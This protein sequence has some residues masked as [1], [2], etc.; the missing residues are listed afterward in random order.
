[1]LLDKLI[2]YAF[3]L[4]NLATYSNCKYIYLGSNVPTYQCIKLNIKI[5]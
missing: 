4:V 5:Q 2:I 1:M 3:Y